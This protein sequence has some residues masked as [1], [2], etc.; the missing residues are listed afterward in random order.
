MIERHLTKSILESLADFPVVLVVGA[1]QVGKSTLVQ[2]LAREQWP[3]RYLTMDDRATL[4]AALT[5]PEGL[6]QELG[7]PVILDEVQRAPDLLRAIK[8]VVDRDRR[9][10][11]FLLAGSANILTLAKVSETLAGRVAVHELHPFSWA[12]L[13]GQPASTA[14]EDL[15]SAK[16]IKNL[17]GR[18][19]SSGRPGRMKE[20]KE[21]ILSGGYP[22]P[23]QMR[24]PS[25]RRTWFESY[26]QTYVE[27]DLRDLAS[28][29][30]LPDFNRLLTT[31]ALRTG[32][33]L[34]FSALSRDVGLSLTTLRRYFNLLEQ[35][36]QVG[37]IPPYFANLGTRLVKTPK[38][39]LNDTGM[40]CHLTV[41]PDWDTLAGRNQA[42]AMLET[43]VAAELRK[44]I[45]LAGYPTSL[46]FWRT[47]LGKEV[48]FILER[49]GGLVGIEVK[50]ASGLD[51]RDLEGLRECERTLA[52]N[53][54]FGL[55]LYGG[56]EVLPLGKKLLAVPFSV[57]LGI[58]G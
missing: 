20:L 23:V 45:A 46:M 54:R 8:L 2:A 58:E 14:L 35:T 56:T 39:Y 26:R 41:A 17:Q 53:W 43:L 27:R 3:A 32:Q 50:L 37:V 51:Q 6:I 19:P 33:M 10:G 30:H 49:G 13:N 31:L 40:A 44:M 25:S 57:F 29:E 21:L 38:L 1:R 34:N 28:I 12:E 16:D 55:V 47:R 48:D 5:N 52:K 24:R 4:D 42:R 18:W 9:P 22:T 15:F 7:Q 11:M 36:C